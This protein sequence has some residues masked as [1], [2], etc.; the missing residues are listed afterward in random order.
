MRRALMAA[1][2]TV[3]VGAGAGFAGLTEALAQPAPPGA[4]GVPTSTPP[5]PVPE[6]VP[7]FNPFAVGAQNAPQSSP[8]E[9]PGARIRPPGVGPPFPPPPRSPFRPPGWDVAP[10]LE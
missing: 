3:A 2:L 10:G 4:R 1:G 5:G 8:P 9:P 7:T 6:R